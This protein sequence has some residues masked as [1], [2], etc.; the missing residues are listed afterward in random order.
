MLVEAAH[1]TFG[2]E[3]RPIVQVE[4]LGLES[5]VCLGIFGPNGVGKTTLVRGLTGLLPAMAGEVKYLRRLRF[6]YLPQHRAMEPHWPM[7]AMDAASM[8]VSARRTLGWMGGAGA[9]ISKAMRAMEVDHL[10]ARPFSQLSGGQQQRVLL[11]GALAAEPEVLV[12]DE[13][14]TGLDVRS[15]QALLDGLRDQN[16]KGLCSV[17]ISH[18]MEDL[19][20]VADEIAW[21]H[22]PDDPNLPSRV[23]VIKPEELAQRVAKVRGRT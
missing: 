8:A 22:W 13:V 1:A 20:E 12:L 10:A 15:R 23:E 21:L 6:G 4:R 3:R 16:R 11:A 5:G 19:L 7:T 2:Y 17:M 9:G 14:T 18:E